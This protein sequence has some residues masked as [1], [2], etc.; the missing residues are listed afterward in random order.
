[1]TA[2]ELARVTAEL[3]ALLPG[4]HV[5]KIRQVADDELVMEFRRGEVR[6]WLTLCVHP[7]V[8]RIHLSGE[9]D[10]QGPELGSFARLVKKTL[11]RRALGG[12]TQPNGDRVLTLFFPSPEGEWRLTAEIF[13]TTGN[14]YLVAPSGIILARALDRAGR[15]AAGAAYAPPPP[16]AHAASLAPPDASLPANRA[17]EERYAGMA[18]AIRIEESRRAALGVVNAERKRLLKRLESVRAEM[19]ALER[20]TGQGRLG[21]LLKANFGHIPRG[22]ASVEVVDLFDPQQGKVAIALDPALSPEENVAAYYKRQRKYDK[23]LSRLG[24]DIAA[25]EDKLRELDG[26]AAAIE[27]EGDAAALAAK[28]PSRKA[29]GPAP[30]QRA[31]Q[32]PSGPRR[33]TSSD[34]YPIFVGRSDAENDELTFRAANGRDLW[35][36]ARDYPGSHVVVRLPKGVEAPRATLLDAAM[37]ALHYS[38]AAKGG[39]GEVTWAH[40][41][42]LKKPKGAPPGK[43]MVMRPK[44]V[45][46]TINRERIE[47]MKAGGGTEG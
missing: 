2:D 43:V 32:K 46:V 47:S 33:F 5:G 42:D 11:E 16:P 40:V 41:K 37:L 23:G 18:R 6:H 36:H 17:M 26:R 19:G 25:M 8:G 10:A 30:R 34:G 44:S 28:A 38:K 39:K 21:D 29:K 13:G 9:P 15:N 45:M 14:I 1:M 3:S 35:L 12:V 22:A 20:W 31:P 4:R 27:A 24:A 7:R